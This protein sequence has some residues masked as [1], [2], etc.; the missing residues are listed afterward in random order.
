M[1]QM[2]DTEFSEADSEH[3]LWDETNFIVS[4]AV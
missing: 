2:N 3:H 4:S 1:W